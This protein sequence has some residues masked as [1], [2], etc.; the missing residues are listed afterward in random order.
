MIHRSDLV[1]EVD[2]LAP[3]DYVRVILGD[4]AS[5]SEG[6]DRIDTIRNGRIFISKQELSELADGP[7]RFE[8]SR[9]D[10]KRIKNGTKQGGK[11]SVS[12]ELK[13]EL[14]LKD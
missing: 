13:R 1:F 5:F 2:G 6:I 9:E 11:L 3:V 10:E 4:T 7:I 12:Y 14:E 8:I